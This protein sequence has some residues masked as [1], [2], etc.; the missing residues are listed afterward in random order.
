MTA[1]VAK[2][3]VKPE[4]REEFERLQSEMRELVHKHEPEAPVYE[5]IKS[6]DDENTYLCVATFTSEDAFN[7]HMSVDFHDRLVPPILDCLAEEMDLAFYDIIG[8][9]KRTA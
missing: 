8:P 1:F 9:A 7:H 4:K 3:V 2:L 5:L 6:R